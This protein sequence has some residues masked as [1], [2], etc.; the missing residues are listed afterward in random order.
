MK[1]ASVATLAVAAILGTF[2]AFA[3]SPPG[4]A[5]ITKAVQGNLAEVQMGRLAQEKGHSDETKAFGQRLVTD[6]SHANERAS[7][8]ASGI[9][10]TPPTEPTAKQRAD[11]DRLA[12]LSGASFDRAF[13]AHMVADH[14]K[15][16]REYRAEAKKKDAAAAY[17]AETLPVLEQH[18]QMAQG[19]AKAKH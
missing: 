5:F 17:A 8:V 6:H 4:Q 16:V 9:G 13:A 10:V 2:P 12:K 7:A 15:D 19:L 18:L 14:E 11:H 3:K 1:P